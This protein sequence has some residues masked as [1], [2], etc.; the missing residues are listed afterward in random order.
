MT[1]F[2]PGSSRDDDV[3]AYSPGQEVTWRYETNRGW[4][5]V[6]FVPAYVVK[7]GP[8]RI[9][10]AALK[11][12]DEWVPRWVKPESLTHGHLSLVAA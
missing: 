9:G 5:Y 3:A 2:T 10:I 4:G 12:N 8:K 1:G 6:F 11:L 7:V